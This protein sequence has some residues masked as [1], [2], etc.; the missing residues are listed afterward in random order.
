MEGTDG[1]GVDV[2]LGRGDLCLVSGELDCQ[3]LRPLTSSKSETWVLMSKE[4]RD[5]SEQFYF[6]VSLL[7]VIL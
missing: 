6:S 1:R 2:C 5:R 3:L 4:Q 7:V